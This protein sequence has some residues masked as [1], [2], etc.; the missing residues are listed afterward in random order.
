[1]TRPETQPPHHHEDRWLTVFEEIK[2]TLEKHNL[3][4]NA[5]YNDMFCHSTITTNANISY[6]FDNDYILTDNSQEQP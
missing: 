3:S 5:T 1:M 2:K 6:H 4:E